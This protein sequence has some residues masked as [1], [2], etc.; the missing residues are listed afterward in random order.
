MTLTVKDVQIL[1]ALKRNA[2]ASVSEIARS[3]GLARATVK[4][5]IQKLEDDGVITGY[6]VRLS[7]E[8]FK[9]HVSGWVLINAFATK[10]ED[11]IAAM[12]DM[13]EIRRI[14]TTNGKWDLSA[15]I[16]AETLQ[17]F[18]QALSRLRQI[19]GVE[20]TSSNLLLSSRKDN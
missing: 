17:K 14:Y 3:C 13:P 18:D 20:E 7:T 10:E 11:V 9:A 12:Q 16:I 6:T 5:R 1:E 2:R 4:N 19:D 8:A 15:V